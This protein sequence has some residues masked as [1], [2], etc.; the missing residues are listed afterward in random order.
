MTDDLQ[1]AI[2]AIIVA[3]AAFM[4]WRALRRP[5]KKC[6][7]KHP[8]APDACDSCPLTDHCRKKQ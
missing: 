4:L 7:K 8:T 5:A 6:D 3:L 1:T 2:V